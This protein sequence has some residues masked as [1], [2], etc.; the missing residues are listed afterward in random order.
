MCFTWFGVKPALPP[1]LEGLP[2]IKLK[3]VAS[4]PN[5]WK[6]D[7]GRAPVLESGSTLHHSLTG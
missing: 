4:D 3:E 7:L 5:D 2:I 1:L 6:F